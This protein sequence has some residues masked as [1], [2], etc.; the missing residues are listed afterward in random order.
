MNS[1]EISA[2][3]AV[4][5]VLQLPTRKP[6][7]SVIFINTFPPAE[8]VELL[9]PLGG[10]GGL[11]WYASCDKKGYRKTNMCYVDNLLLENEDKENDDELLPDNPGVS[12]TQSKELKKRTQARI[13][14]GVWFN[15]EAQPE[16]HR[17]LIMLFTSWRNEETDLL[18][19]YSMFEEHYLA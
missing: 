8:R 5:V 11:S 7:R 4:Y 12:S 13:I 17:E 6:S 1:V 19:K 9:R 18:K 2:Q 16:K 14:R 3:E 15:K 10:V